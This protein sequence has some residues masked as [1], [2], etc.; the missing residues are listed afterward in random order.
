MEKHFFDMKIDSINRDWLKKLE[1]EKSKVLFKNSDWIPEW[2]NIKIFQWIFSQ[3]FKKWEKSRN[4]YKYDQEGWFVDNY[5]RL[6]IMLWQHDDSYGWIWFVNELYVDTKGNLAWIFYVDLDMLEDRHRKQVE[7]WFVT[8]VSTWAITMEA[9][10]E[11]N[12]NWKRYTQD[13]AVEEFW[14][15]NVVEALWGDVNAILTYVVTKAELVENS[16]VTIWSNFWAIAKSVNSIWDEMNTIANQMKS[17]QDK[18]NLFS[19]N[20]TMNLDEAMKEIETLWNDVS[21]RDTKLNALTDE[22][23][24]KAKKIDSLEKDV[25]AKEKEI[26]TLKDKSSKNEDKLEKLEK[27]A[28]EKILAA[29]KIDNGWGEKVETDKVETEEDFVKKYSK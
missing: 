29:A 5:K 19:K 25:E 21:E 10:Y 20:S 18:N 13:E 22:V 15:S 1:W 17:K 26:N 2:D 11:H 3:N 12:E 27:D 16:L 4:W 28:K 9:M 6:P 24:E 7:K 23:S 8:M 14:Y